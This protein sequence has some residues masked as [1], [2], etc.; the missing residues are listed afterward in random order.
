MKEKRAMVIPRRKY[1][2]RIEVFALLWIEFQDVPVRRTPY[3]M[4]PY[5][6]CVSGMLYNYENEDTILW[7]TV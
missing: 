1:Y 2:H 5:R 6:M 4:A 3:R 7:T